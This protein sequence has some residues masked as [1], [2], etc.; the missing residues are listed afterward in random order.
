MLLNK[1]ALLDP[2]FSRL[3]SEQR[4]LNSDRLSRQMK[5]NEAD[6]DCA[7]EVEKAAIALGAMGSLFV[8]KPSDFGKSSS[9]GILEMKA[10]MKEPPLSADSKPLLWC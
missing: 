10:Y 4:N 2:W 8:Y 7:Q 5:E 3:S 9:D 1:P 6:S